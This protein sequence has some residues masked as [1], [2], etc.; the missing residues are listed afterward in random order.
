MVT[1][2]FKELI[3]YIA[4]CNG[5]GRSELDK[6]I[7]AG[8]VTKDDADLIFYYASIKKLN[9]KLDNIAKKAQAVI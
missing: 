9:K 1:D 7:A 4:S 5:D 8:V 6:K 3:A 2:Q